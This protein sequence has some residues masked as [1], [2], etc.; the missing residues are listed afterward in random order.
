MIK[1]KKTISLLNTTN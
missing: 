1:K